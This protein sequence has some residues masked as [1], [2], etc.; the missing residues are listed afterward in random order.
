MKKIIT[1]AV[2]IAA[3][4]SFTATA[5]EEYQM[6]S[7]TGGACAFFYLGAEQEKKSEQAGKISDKYARKAG[8]SESQQIQAIANVS[9]FF[10]P[11]SGAWINDTCNKLLQAY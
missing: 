3:S 10:E 2:I 1:L 8:M 11:K 5:N 7:G 9:G 6:V 4:A